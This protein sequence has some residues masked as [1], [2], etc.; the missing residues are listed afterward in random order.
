MTFGGWAGKQLQ[1][2]TD[3]AAKALKRTPG[4]DYLANPLVAQDIMGAAFAGSLAR[5]ADAKTALMNAGGASGD[6]ASGGSSG[7][8]SDLLAF[9]AALATGAAG[10]AA[11]PLGASAAIPGSALAGVGAGA[12]A[13][14]LAM[15]LAAG[16]DARYSGLMGGNQSQAEAPPDVNEAN[17]PAMA[18]QFKRL[19]KAARSLGRAGTFKNKGAGTSLGLGDSVLGDQLSLIG[20]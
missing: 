12:A 6:L 14:A 18:A 17:D 5:G 11:L 1:K 10:G 3:K 19:R 15:P 7:Q 20:S 8:W 4:L 2:G 13:G 16:A 9:N